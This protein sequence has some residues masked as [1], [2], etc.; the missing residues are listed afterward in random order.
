MSLR[1]YTA[2]ERLDLWERGIESAS[3][4]PEYNLHGDVL[5]QWWGH[6]GEELRDYQFV[7]YDDVVDEVVAEG[8]TGPFRWDGDD[9]SLPTG[10]DAV[11]ELIF[12]QHRVGEVPNTLCALAAET[13]RENQARGMASQLLKGMRTLAERQG[14]THLVAPVRPSLKERYP[15]IP[16]ERYITWR[17]GDQQLF[18]PWMRIHERMGARV[19]TPLP[20]SMLI[21]GPVEDWEAWTS[22]AFPESG[23]YTFPE[24]LA[25]LQIDRA[26]DR[27]TNWEP[28]VWMIHPD[29][30]K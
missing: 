1:M 16:I 20:Q 3:V 11:I 6:L 19:V 5:N 17:R 4:W 24:G 14:L 27:G 15:L 22:M 28:N 30:R 12:R 9:E 25:T 2:A 13:P 29:I 21:S 7:L 10:I 18:D 23:E 8:H 26:R